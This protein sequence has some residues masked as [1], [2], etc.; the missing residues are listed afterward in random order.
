MRG[1]NLDGL[2]NINVELTSRCNKNCWMCGRRKVEKDYPELALEY[3]D[4]DFL[5]VEKIADELP[6]NIVVQFHNNGEA[7]LY[8]RFGEAVKLFKNQIKNVVTNG[9][10]LVEKADEIIDNLDTVAISIIEN[11]D[12]AD[13]QY[14]VI[15]KFLKIKRDR[16][17][18][19]ILRLNGDVDQEKYKKFGLIMATRILHSPM[20]SFNYRRST[21]IPEIGI[22]LDFL[23]HLAINSKGKVSICVRFDPKG[24]GIIGDMNNQSLAEI[25]NSPQRLEWLAYHKQGRRDQVP[26]CSYCHFWGVPTGKDLQIETAKIKED[27]ILSR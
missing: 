15:E 13:E 9:K 20:G 21:T 17:P 18:L 2:A 11:D 22:C 23:N 10:L 24:V 25:W 12:E 7:L 26:L 3:G 19:T 5:R 16:K 4:I 27:N 8:P 14:Q 6:P 1:D